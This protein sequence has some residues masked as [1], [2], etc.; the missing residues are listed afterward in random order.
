MRNH[1]DMGSS[2]H[3]TE[4]DLGNIFTSPELA[5]KRA[6]DPSHSLL[7]P[8]TCGLCKASLLATAEAEKEERKQQIQEALDGQKEQ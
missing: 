2:F 4:D 6:R 3:E 1:K 7:I 8:D 5:H